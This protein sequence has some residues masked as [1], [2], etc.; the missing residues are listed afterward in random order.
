MC[1]TDDDNDRK[2]YTT[3]HFH[4]IGSEPDLCG[5]ILKHQDKHTDTLKETA[6]PLLLLW[7]HKVTPA[8]AS[9]LLL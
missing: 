3:K 6:I 8:A 7:K 9:P 2:K 4:T 5:N 1:E